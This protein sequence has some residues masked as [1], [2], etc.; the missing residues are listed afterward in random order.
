MNKTDMAVQSYIL[1]LLEAQEPC[2]FEQIV[3]EVASQVPGVSRCNAVPITIDA[4]AKLQQ[5]GTICGYHPDWTEGEES[6]LTYSFVLSEESCSSR[7]NQSFL[8]PP[9]N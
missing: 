1:G 8:L 4:I 6:F 7:L 5:E 9:E 3:T 2:T